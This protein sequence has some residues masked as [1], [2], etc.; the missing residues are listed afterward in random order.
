[1][2]FKKIMITI[3][4]VKDQIIFKFKIYIFNFK[5]FIKLFNYI[6]NR[7]FIRMF[8]NNTCISHKLITKKVIINIMYTKYNTNL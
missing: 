6:T 4:R 7:I 5:L 3:L 2:I 8:K 1:M